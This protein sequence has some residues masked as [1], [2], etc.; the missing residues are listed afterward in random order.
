MTDQNGSKDVKP[1]TQMNH[2]RRSKRFGWLLEA[3]LALAVLFAPVAANAMEMPSMQKSG[4]EHGQAA[5]S[6]HC[7]G[8]ED[9][10][11]K[12]DEGLGQAC[13][14]AM[15]VGIA[16]LAPTPTADSTIVQAAPRPFAPEFLLGWPTELPTPPP[17][18]A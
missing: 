13:C 7:P 3:F 16:I 18:L 9:A 1:G 11:S 4:D 2:I 5:P 15:C 8:D 17:R 12:G 14:A 6:D 10:G